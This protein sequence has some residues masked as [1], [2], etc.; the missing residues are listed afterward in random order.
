MTGDGLDNLRPLTAATWVARGSAALLI[1]QGGTLSFAAPRD[2]TWSSHA[3]TIYHH[4]RDRDL[5]ALCFDLGR[6]EPEFQIGTT[7]PGI[8][9]VSQSS[10]WCL[11]TRQPSLPARSIGP[12]KNQIRPLHQDYDAAETTG[13]AGSWLREDP[14]R[15]GT[16][17]LDRRNA[18]R[19][20]AVASH[21][22]V[23]IL[24]PRSPLNLWC[25]SGP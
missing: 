12:G 22:G 16:A 13:F 11:N 24:R 14:G 25:A 21:H 7:S 9:T 4:D 10:E 6:T 1:G 3:A 18:T 8:I 19:T 23:L 2:R 17:A 5:R 20:A 15:L